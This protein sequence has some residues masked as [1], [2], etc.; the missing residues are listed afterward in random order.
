MK[1]VE[2]TGT[3]DGPTIMKWLKENPVNDFFAQNGKIRK[4]GLMVHDMYLMQV[5]SPGES[6]GPWDYYKQIAHVP[7]D[8]VHTSVEES[9]CRL[10]KEA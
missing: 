7:G 6:T 4:D 2:A 5:K 8:K 1:A 9:T 10:F 3:T